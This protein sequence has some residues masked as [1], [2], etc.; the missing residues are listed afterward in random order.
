MAAYRKQRRLAF[1][2][3]AKLELLRN[4]CCFAHRADRTIIFTADNATAY[5]VSRRFL[6]PVITHQ[7]KV[8]ERSHILAGLSKVRTVRWSRRA[9]S[10]KG[11]TCPKPTWRSFSRGAARCASTCSAWA[12]LAQERRQTRD[13]LRARDPSD[14]RDVHQREEARAQCLPLTW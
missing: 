9:C 14:E 3:P 10:T 11:S 4:S 6:V 12:H 13:P 7:T 8:K 5:E 2:A 1:A